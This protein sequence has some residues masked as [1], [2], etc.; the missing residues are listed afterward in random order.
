MLAEDGEQ[1]GMFG[2][3]E[4]GRGVSGLVL[5]IIFTSIYAANAADSTKAMRIKVLLISIVRR[6]R[7]SFSI[8]N[9][10]AKEY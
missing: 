10:K 8:L 9:A 6:N 7:C 3:L 1:G 4:A 2:S 5:T